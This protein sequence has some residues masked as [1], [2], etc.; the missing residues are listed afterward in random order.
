[1]NTKI[2]P[3]ALTNSHHLQRLSASNPDIEVGPFPTIPT[4]NLQLFLSGDGYYLSSLQ[5]PR[6]E[7]RSSRLLFSSPKS[8]YTTLLDLVLLAGCPS[9]LRSFLFAPDQTLLYLRSHFLS[10]FFLSSTPSTLPLKLTRAN[11]FGSRTLDPVFALLIGFSA[12]GMRIRREENEK[13]LGM[14]T[15]SIVGSTGQMPNQKADPGSQNGPSG[16]IGYAEIASLGWGRIKR[17]ISEAVQW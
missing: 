7:V 12:A 16:E 13:R 17:K 1:M 9:H 8:L 11:T 2:L 10:S 15:T 6:V 5:I 4:L 14:A 3:S